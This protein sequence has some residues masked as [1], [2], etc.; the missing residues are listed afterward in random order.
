M[1]HSK[2]L[3]W[4]LTLERTGKIVKVKDYTYV[5]TD[6]GNKLVHMFSNAGSLLQEDTVVIKTS[7][8]LASRSEDDFDYEMLHKSL[9]DRLYKHKKRKQIAG[10]GNVAFIPSI[11]DLNNF[12]RRFRNEY[13]ELWDREKIERC[14]LSHIDKCCKTDKFSPAIKYFIIKEG[15]GSQLAS[16]L[17]T[18]EDSTPTESD[19]K[20]HDITNLKDLF[21]E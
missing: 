5:L 19:D 9:Q 7:P 1:Q 20:Q 14:L 13:P 21:D 3:S 8:V 4:L 10:F 11:K 17:D 16:Y 6:E 18:A 2:V 12:L 15:A